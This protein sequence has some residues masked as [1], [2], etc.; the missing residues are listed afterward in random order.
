MACKILLLPMLHLEAEWFFSPM[1]WNQLGRGFP[2]PEGVL[3]LLKRR[4]KKK[5]MKV[6]A[7]TPKRKNMGF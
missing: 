3:N 6:L 7:L 4:E 2:N 5:K 1:G